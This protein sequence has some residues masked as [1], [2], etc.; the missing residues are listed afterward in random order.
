MDDLTRERWPN[1]HPRRRFFDLVEDAVFSERRVVL[2]GVDDVKDVAEQEQRR[3]LRRMARGR[4][5]RLVQAI[6]R[7]SA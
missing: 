4:E 7:Y 6:R 1:V 5:G 2:C 3:R